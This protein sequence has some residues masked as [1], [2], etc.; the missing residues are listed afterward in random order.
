MDAGARGIDFAYESADHLPGT[1]AFRRRRH[2]SQYGFGTASRCRRSWLRP[3]MLTFVISP[4]LR[5]FVAS[6]TCRYQLSKLYC[7]ESR[8]WK[9]SFWRIFGNASPP[10]HCHARRP[11]PALRLAVKHRP[12]ADHWARPSTCSQ[13]P[14]VASWAPP[15]IWSMT[16]ARCTGTATC[17]RPGVGTRSHRGSLCRGR[18]RWPGWWHRRGGRTGPA[19]STAT[20]PRFQVRFAG[21]GSFSRSACDSNRGRMV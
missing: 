17:A 14:A 6:R 10:A 7:N 15:A 20:R 19:L 3:D 13:T 2:A 8:A 21:P 11:T 1:Y 4:I 18:R 12:L 5:S 16:I 9:S